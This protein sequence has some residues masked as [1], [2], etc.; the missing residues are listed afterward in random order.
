MR[1]I[2][3]APHVVLVGHIDGLQADLEDIWVS[4]CGV[5]C[6][7]KCG[8]AFRWGLTKITQRGIIVALNTDISQCLGYRS[9]FRCIFPDESLL[10]VWNL[11]FWVDY[12][13]NSYSSQI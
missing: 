7:Q 8:K 4:K 10:G 11:A 12:S 13:Y 2:R 1:R 5:R 9:L 3:D 6:T